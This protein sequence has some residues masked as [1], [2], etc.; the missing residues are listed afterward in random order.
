MDRILTTFWIDLFNQLASIAE[1]KCSPDEPMYCPSRMLGS[2]FE[3]PSLPIQKLVNSGDRRIDIQSRTVFNDGY[4]KGF[5]PPDSPFPPWIFQNSFNKTFRL[6]G[7]TIKGTTSTFD[8]SIKAK[9]KLKLIDPDDPSKG[10]LL[11]YE[12]P[13]FAVFYDILKVVSEDLIV[14]KAFTGIYPHGTLILNF[15]M[16]RRYGFD[17]M[18]PQDHNEI[19]TNNGKV[20][21]IEK[22]RG[23]WE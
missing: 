3:K 13:Q 1:S 16:A 19:F 23:E 17:F 5:F 8:D 21:D 11:E 22:V 2:L 9:N 10:I 12:E 15:T 20:P 7:D 4:W 14:G 18:S 6:E